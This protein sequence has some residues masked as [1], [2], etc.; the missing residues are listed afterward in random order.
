M[1]FCKNY[2]QNLIVN[3]DFEDHQELTKKNGTWDDFE[4]IPGWNTTGAEIEIQ[5]GDFDTGNPIGNSVAELDS[6]ENY[7]LT[8]QVQVS[9]AGT[10]EFSADYAMRGTSAETNG[11]EVY[12]NG[13]LEMTVNPTDPGFETGTFDVY[14]DDGAADIEIRGIG[15][16]D[17]KGTVVDNV[18]LTLVEVDASELTFKQKA[19]WLLSKV[20]CSLHP[21]EDE[22]VIV[23]SEPE[24]D[25][26]QCVLDALAQESASEPE[27]DAAAPLENVALAADFEA[28]ASDEFSFA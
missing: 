16:S 23:E 6:T 22:L 10:Y 24:L 8:Q 12:V 7:G 18:S 19:G 20:L 13:E 2:K 17:K 14:L 11:F 28:G 27:A 1:R 25:D 4:S 3:G 5:E 15:T 21:E 9:Y 26:D